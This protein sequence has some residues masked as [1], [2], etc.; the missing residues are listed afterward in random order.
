M[1]QEEPAA[2]RAEDQRAADAAR[3]AVAPAPRSTGGRARQAV[4]DLL[5]C[6]HQ[7]Q[8]REAA[9][10]AT[11]AAARLS[12][13]AR[14]REPPTWYP[15]DWWHGLDLHASNPR[16][17]DPGCT[18]IHFGLAFAEIVRQMPDLLYS[19]SHGEV[20]YMQLGGHRDYWSRGRHFL[21]A[22]NS[23]AA[24]LLRNVTAGMTHHIGAD[25]VINYHVILASGKVG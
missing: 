22:G 3:Q 9:A 24:Q 8:A 14:Q 18:A 25:K 19:T 21:D 23:W 20:V 11:A 4:A 17:V 7:G 12:V 10:A 6:A 16:N 5:D 2:C 15:V 13:V 1:A